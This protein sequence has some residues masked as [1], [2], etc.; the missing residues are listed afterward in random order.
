MMRSSQ[1]PAALSP[2]DLEPGM[3]VAVVMYCVPRGLATVRLVTDTMVTLTHDLFGTTAGWTHD[4]FLSDIG[5][6]PYNENIWNPTNRL[7]RLKDG[8]SG[9]MPPLETT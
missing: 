5:A 7:E 2:Q 8:D 4:W 6:V 9:Y 3:R 1:Y